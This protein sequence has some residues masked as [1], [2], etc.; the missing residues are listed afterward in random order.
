MSNIAAPSPTTLS[1]DRGQVATLGGA[2][3]G[4]FVV[5]VEPRIVNVA[6]P[7]IGAAFGGG[8]SGLQFG[9]TATVVILGI[10]AAPSRTLR[11]QQHTTGVN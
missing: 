8:L 9:L 5:A 6:L 7:D 4:F 2:M 3:L 10:T 11:S 1:F